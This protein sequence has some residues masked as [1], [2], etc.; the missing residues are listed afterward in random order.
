MRLTEL[1]RR[2]ILKAEVGALINKFKIKPRRTILFFEKILADYIKECEN[3]GYAKEMRNI[4]FKWAFVTTQVLVPAYLKKLPLSISGNVIINKLWKS[5]GLMN[6]LNITTKNSMVNVKTQNEFITRV[7][8]KNEFMNGFGMGVISSIYKSVAIPVRTIQTKGNCE[9]IYKITQRSLIVKTKKK[10]I[11]YRLNRITPREG[12][13]LKDFLKVGFVKIKDNRIYFK[14]SP[15]LHIENTVFHL[16]GNKEILLDSL[17]K[18]SYDYFKSII[19]I[20][21]PIERKL[22]LIKNLLQIMGWGLID[23]KY[24]KHNKI[25]IEIK[26]PPFGLQIEK[27]NW[28]LL[29]RVILGYLWLIDK[30]L[31]IIKYEEDRKK[32]RIYF[33]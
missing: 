3:A 8:G 4:G 27:D 19:G 28:I 6:E 20:N 12:V 1:L 5:I 23:I 22:L 11:Y 14:N 18:I 33:G 32:L 10:S 16:I 24:C 26:N 13:E 17:Q 29:S 31:R 25:L 2:G 21:L 15:L 30:K 7:I 9:Y